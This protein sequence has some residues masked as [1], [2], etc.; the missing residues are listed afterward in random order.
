M[1]LNSRIR[2]FA[3]L[4]AMAAA[5]LLSSPGVRVAVAGENESSQVERFLVQN[6]APATAGPTCDA[7]KPVRSHEASIQNALAQAR[8]QLAAMP[9]QGTYLEGHRGVMMLN[10]R[11]FNY[12]GGETFPFAPGALPKPPQ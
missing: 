3:G 10:N 11:G 6:P 1:R 12:A 9:P 4:L 2:L 5:A 8:A 7:Q